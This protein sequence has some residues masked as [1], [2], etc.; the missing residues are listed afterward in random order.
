MPTT[1]TNVRKMLVASRF[2]WPLAMPTRDQVT[3]PIAKTTKPQPVARAPRLAGV[4]IAAIMVALGGDP[5]GNMFDHQMRNSHAPRE[6]RWKN[7]LPLVAARTF[8]VAT[9]ILSG[10]VG[11]SLGTA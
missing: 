6:F 8:T 11:Y 2:V 1:L 9:G 4:V 3:A 7:L 5:S 10:L